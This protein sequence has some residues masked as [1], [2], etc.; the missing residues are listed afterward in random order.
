MYKYKKTIIINNRRRRIFCKEKS[1]N[2]YILYKNNYITLNS[3]YKKTGGGIMKYITNPSNTTK[4][5]LSDSYSIK[6]FDI[7]Y[8][9][10]LEYITQKNLKI[11]ID[12]YKFDLSTIISSYLKDKSKINTKNTKIWIFT[13]I[14]NNDLK[15][16]GFNDKNEYQQYIDDLNNEYNLIQ[17]GN[18]DDINISSVKLKFGNIIT[19][20]IIPTQEKLNNLLKFNTNNYINDIGYEV[21][22]KLYNKGYYIY[23]YKNNN[24]DN[25][26]EGDEYKLYNCIFRCEKIIAI[27]N[28][29]IGNG[30]GEFQ[31]NFKYDI[32]FKYISKLNTED[33]IIKFGEKH[34]TF[35]QF[36]IDNDKRLFYN[37]LVSRDGRKVYDKLNIDGYYIYLVKKYSTND[38]VKY[39]ENAIYDIYDTKFICYKIIKN[40]D[41]NV[42]FKYLGDFTTKKDILLYGSLYHNTKIYENGLLYYK[43]VNEEGKKIYDKLIE[44]Q[45]NVYYT[46]I[47]H[48]TDNEYKIESI[49]KLHDINKI[50]KCVKI[51]EEYPSIF[52]KTIV[53]NYIGNTEY[54][55]VATVGGQRKYKNFKFKKMI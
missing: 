41:N 5:F 16:K 21:Y 33:E 13:E 11:K 2:E 20:E 30:H 6:E 38:L 26:K 15:I 9:D 53:F 12:T 40:G 24:Y 4:R 47:V 39:V 22:D 32:L 45:Y 28:G 37:K 49:Y 31:K 48:C 8:N 14:N 43:Y 27:E 10:F 3:Y 35:N 50:F 1:N 44:E 46:E 52:Q 17:Y 54:S 55:T 34:N 51:I 7:K 25:F 19:N 29:I 36:F 23:I 42:I 18:S